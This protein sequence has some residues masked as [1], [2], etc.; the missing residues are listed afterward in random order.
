MARDSS[1]YLIAFCSYG[2]TSLVVSKFIPAIVDL[3]SDPTAGVRDA[4]F[5]TLVEIYKHI[6][7]RVRVDLQKKH[8]VPPAK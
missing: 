4:A 3:L 5:S 2:A 7:E 1:T 6:G 8:Q